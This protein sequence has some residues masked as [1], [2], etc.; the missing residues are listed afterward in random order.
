MPSDEELAVRVAAG[1][2]FALAELVRRYGDG[3]RRFVDRQT[4]GRDVDDLG[5]DTWLR[6]VRSADRFDR[7]RKFSTWLFQ[8]CI[9]LCRDWH[10][11]QNV[12]RVADIDPDTLEGASIRTTPIDVASALASIPVEQREVIVLRYYYDMSEQDMAD[13]TGVPRGTVKSRL[14]AGLK[15]LSRLLGEESQT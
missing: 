7:N 14:H 15:A 1:D 10:R 9:N 12:R 8:I 2:E 5:Q 6:V 13:S 3:I 11:R 4:G